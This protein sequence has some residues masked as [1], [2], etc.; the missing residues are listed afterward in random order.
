V[1][2]LNRAIKT[3]YQQLM[4]RKIT[5]IIIKSM[6]IIITMKKKEPKYEDCWS[7]KGFDKDK[8]LDWLCGETFSDFVERHKKPLLAK[9]QPKNDNK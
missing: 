2:G 6:H 5:C 9:T 7:K 4:H 3:S 8:F 1:K